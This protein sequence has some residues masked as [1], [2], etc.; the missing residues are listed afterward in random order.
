MRPSSAG[1][2]V[3][4][5]CA[6][7]SLFDDFHRRPI[8]RI[9]A[10]IGDAVGARVR[11]QQDQRVAKVDGAAFAVL[12][13]ALVEDL[14]EEFVHVGVRLLDFIE[15]HDAMRAAAHGFG[16]HAAFA[17]ADIAGRR[18]LQQRD[19]VRFLILAH[20]DGDQVL[21]AAVQ[22][23]GQRQRGLGLADAGRA[24]EQEYARPACPDCPTPRATSACAGR[25][26]ASR[27]AGR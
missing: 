6:C 9:A 8:E 7:S 14:E 3:C 13:P 11:G 5:N 27:A 19:R 20:V 16:Q 22:H 23:L 10:Q 12:H 1:G 17:E 26:S 24:G 2:N 18:A 21:L 4:S 15:Q 25:S